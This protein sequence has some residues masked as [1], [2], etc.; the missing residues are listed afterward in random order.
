[1][2]TRLDQPNDGDRKILTA[3]Q[4]K[5]HIVKGLQSCSLCL[6]Q[7]EAGAESYSRLFNVSVDSTL[8]DRAR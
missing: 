7:L 5:K 3:S 2:T 4:N 1:M 8:P 6:Y